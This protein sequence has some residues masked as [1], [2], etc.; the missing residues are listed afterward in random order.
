MLMIVGPNLNGGDANAR[1]WSVK[2]TW[3]DACCCKVSCPC[4]FGSKPT[5]GYCEGASLLEIDSGYYG[6]VKL[7][8]VAVVA[9]YRV[10]KWAKIYV[11]DTASK[12][13]VEALGQ[14]MPKAMP[15]LGKGPIKKIEA[16]SLQVERGDELIKYSVPE[17]SVEI[18]PV[19]GA[20]GEVIKLQNLPASGTP[21]PLVHEHAQ[22][23]EFSW[24]GRNAFV[25]KVDL[26]NV[27]DASSEVQE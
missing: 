9:T 11:S 7:N 2:G 4:L 17:T 23:D 8:G 24:S 14:V 20:N 18:A 25:S 3:T 22:Y 13:Q 27:K 5:E 19:K 15:F 1:S 21:F 10:G 26:V 6:D 12:E 16:V